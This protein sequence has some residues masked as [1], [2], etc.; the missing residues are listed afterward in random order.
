MMRP[1]EGMWPGRAGKRAG[2]RRRLMNIKFDAARARAGLTSETVRVRES[3][4]VACQ[5][6]LPCA[7]D[8]STVECF[9]V[10]C[11]VCLSEFVLVVVRAAE[12][13]SVGTDTRG[14]EKLDVCVAQKRSSDL[15]PYV[16]WHRKH[17]QVAES[18]EG[19]LPAGSDVAGPISQRQ[20]HEVGEP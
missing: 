4:L 16:V 7:T 15:R 11:V 17:N 2:T 19:T 10:S 13:H 12:K 3:H 5:R 14:D 20:E 6:G 8:G 1:S 9:I 18:K